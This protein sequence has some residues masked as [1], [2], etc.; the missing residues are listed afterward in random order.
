[1]A[2]LFFEFSFFPGVRAYAFLGGCPSCLRRFPTSPPP[3][4]I[5]NKT[6]MFYC[7]RLETSLRESETNP[8][9]TVFLWID[10]SGYFQWLLQYLSVAMPADSR[11]ERKVW[12]SVWDRVC[13]TVRSAG[14]KLMGSWTGLKLSRGCFGAFFIFFVRTFGFT[15]RFGNKNLPLIQKLKWN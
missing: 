11:C 4:K 8:K 9:D 10:F 12:N 3:Q 7:G 6:C 1:M 13:K 14:E 2:I 5:K 15:F